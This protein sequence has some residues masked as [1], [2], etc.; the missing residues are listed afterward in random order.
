VTVSVLSPST[1]VDVDGYENTIPAG[2]IV[3][4]EG[5]TNIMDTEDTPGTIFDPSTDRKTFNFTSL[6]QLEWKLVWINNTNSGAVDAQ[7][8]DAIPDDT[9]Y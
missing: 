2:T 4:D 3:T 8:S 7:I 5:Y 6:P 9:T 1:D